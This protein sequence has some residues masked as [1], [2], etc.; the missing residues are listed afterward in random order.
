VLR[1]AIDDYLKRSM[2]PIAAPIVGGMIISTIRLLI[3]VPVFFA[4]MKERAL[5]P[6]P[7]RRKN[8]RLSKHLLTRKA[9]LR[10][11]QA[12]WFHSSGSIGSLRLRSVGIG[13]RSFW[14]R[15]LDH[16][17]EVL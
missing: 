17:T 7:R 1:A 5:R 9:L 12:D 11:R 3:L 13:S 6:G 2:K 8:C 10:S 14:I 15:V 16:S 4:L